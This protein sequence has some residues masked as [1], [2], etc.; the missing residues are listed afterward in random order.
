M[1][2]SSLR[3][4]ISLV[5]ISYDAAGERPVFFASRMEP[6]A[7]LKRGKDPTFFFPLLYFNARLLCPHALSSQMDLWDTLSDLWPWSIS[8]RGSFGSL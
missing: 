1:R 4:M 8:R 3:S 5:V 2:Y 7:L 6:I